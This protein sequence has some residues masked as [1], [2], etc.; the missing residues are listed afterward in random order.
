MSVL[1]INDHWLKGAGAI[2]VITGKLSDVAGLF[3]FV[4]F[5]LAGVRS[6]RRARHDVMVLLALIASGHARRCAAKG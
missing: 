5:V 4:A 3:F 2:E 6:G 1:A